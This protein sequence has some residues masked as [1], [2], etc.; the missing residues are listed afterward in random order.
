MNTRPGFA[1]STPSD[2]PVRPAGKPALMRRH[3]A[4]LSSDWAT[5][6]FPVAYNEFGTL[7]SSVK[8]VTKLNPAAGGEIGFHEVPPSA[9]YCNRA[10]PF[11]SRT[12]I[13]FESLAATWR[14]TTFGVNTLG[15]GDV[16]KAPGS[17]TQLAPS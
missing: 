17:W 6:L 1:G 10:G 13:W 5:P 4:P 15:S 7:R 11:V 14:R 3:V 8:S 12:K 9:L 2:A 16:P